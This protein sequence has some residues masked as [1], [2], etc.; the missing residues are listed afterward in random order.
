MADTDHDF[1]VRATWFA[2]RMDH[3]VL[4]PL[5]SVHVLADALTLAFSLVVRVPEHDFIEV[6]FG[7]GYVLGRL[8]G[9]GGGHDGGGG[10]GTTA[11]SR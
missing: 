9:G 10:S 8:R 1:T 4:A 2:T 11:L 7:V 5:A 6:P 3:D